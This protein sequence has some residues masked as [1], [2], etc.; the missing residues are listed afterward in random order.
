MKLRT[1]LSLK[2]SQFVLYFQD[3][4]N[5]GED[6]IMVKKTNELCLIARNNYLERELTDPDTRYFELIL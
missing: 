4:L 3:I 5:L 2:K 6:D 1:G